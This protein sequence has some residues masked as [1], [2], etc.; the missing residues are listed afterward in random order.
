MT[1]TDVWA[2]RF[3]P[4]VLPLPS[5]EG[6]FALGVAALSID[7]RPM[8]PLTFWENWEVPDAAVGGRTS[9]L[10]IVDVRLSILCSFG[11]GV[12]LCTVARSGPPTSTDEGV[13]RL[14]IPSSAVREDSPDGGRADGGREFDPGLA[15]LWST[16]AR[17]DGFSWR[18][19]VSSFNVTGGDPSDVLGRDPFNTSFNRVTDETPYSAPN[20]WAAAFLGIWRQSGWSV[21]VWRCATSGFRAWLPGMEAAGG[22]KGVSLC[23]RPSS[24]ISVVALRIAG[25]P[26]C[27][28]NVL[29]GISCSDFKCL[30]HSRREVPPV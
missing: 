1:A 25:C 4:V 24:P 15:G 26:W 30:S 18:P 22:G 29:G 19:D 21:S 17:T 14:W 5:D 12:I 11:E 23:F 3:P 2:P 13:F 8:K 20:G 7:S 9:R 16:E 6:L 27:T 28:A 10:L